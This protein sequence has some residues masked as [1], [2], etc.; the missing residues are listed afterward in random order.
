MAHRAFEYHSV[1]EWSKLPFQIE[2]ID[3]WGSL[4]LIGTSKGQLLV[5]E[6]QPSG[7]RFDVV[8]KDTKK[9]FCAEKR[10]I[11]Q[12]TVIEEFGLLL[13]LSNGLVNVHDLATLTLRFRIESSA[14]CKM[15]A[16]DVQV[17]DD[18]EADTHR[19]SD[20]RVGKR[21]SEL[22]LR[23]CVATKRRLVTYTWSG[24]DFQKNK[25]LAL[26]DSAKTVQWCGGSLCVGFKKE[27]NKIAEQSGSIAEVF[28]TGNNQEPT[29]NRI[30]GNEILLGKDN[31]SIYVGL[32]CRPT[33]KYAISWSDTPLVV[34]MA[35]PFVV[36]VLPKTVEVRTSESVALVQTMEL[37]RARFFAQNESVY[38]ASP[39]TC[40]RLEMVPF[41]DQI[42]EL[43]ELEEFEEALVL[44]EL[45]EE[46]AEHKAER[47]FE[48]KTDYAYTQFACK[49]FDRALRTFSELDIDPP[50]VIGLY[51]DLLPAELR[52]HFTRKNRKQPP[53]LDATELET[54]IK[55]LIEY[56][57]QKRSD[58]SKPLPDDAPRNETVNRKQLSEIIDTTL[59]KCYLQ[60]NPSLA[61][62]L[63]RVTNRCNLKESEK[64][65]MQAKRFRELVDLY[66]NRG[67]HEKALALLRA[68]ADQPGTLSGHTH[69]QDYL[70]RLGPTHLELIFQYSPYVLERHEQDGFAIFASDDYPE[71]RTLPQDKV[72]E[73]LETKAPKLL[74]PYLEHVIRVW[75]NQLPKFHNKLIVLYLDELQTRFLDYVDSLDQR[76]PVIPPGSEPAPLGKQRLRLLQFLQWSKAYEATQLITRFMDMKAMHEELAILHGRIG[77][78]DEA[79]KIYAYTLRDAEKAE[80]Y[81]ATV[82]D[83]EVESARN[84][85]IHLLQV[86]LQPREGERPNVAAA[87][88]I[89]SVFHERID[90]NKA[91]NMLPST[92]KVAD[93]HEFLISVMRDRA[94][95]RRKT[96]VLK[97]L[98]KAERLQVNDELFQYHARKMT[99]TDDKLCSVCRKGIGT[100]A[101]ACYPNGI[102]VHLHCASKDPSICPC[103]NPKCSLKHAEKP[104]RQASGVA[105]SNPAA[106]GSSSRSY[107]YGGGDAFGGFSGGSSGW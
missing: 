48:I 101:F 30:P 7:G 34:G 84:V 39:T 2:S 79:L 96:Q 72:A 98:H 55:A 103:T 57:T 80:Q 26:P 10:P 47:I 77:N 15:Y 75:D 102:V 49:H 83:A 51:P 61:A 52:E 100:K 41:E 24:A 74:V 9:Q 59:L 93:I 56:L 46:S 38:V 87:L 70:Q 53:Q 23:L 86:Y 12:L 32:D 4:L 6:I 85:Y 71:I 63:L 45:I 73:F 11:Q 88:R 1:V 25:E 22:R 81:C 28:K 3:T 65:L 90:T 17:R 69:L 27:Y 8:L 91:M 67:L 16:A 5:Y 95:E 40:W 31:L 78:H 107:G 97:S 50:Q 89:L 104:S 42:R 106:S 44:A 37:P 58:L 54:A 19:C 36:A 33:R 92:T 62:S 43:L 99:I 105:T 64:M 68:Q 14:G 18:L 76:N 60:T 94:Q 66:R 35:N 21:I 82:Y 29:S 13:S 20:A